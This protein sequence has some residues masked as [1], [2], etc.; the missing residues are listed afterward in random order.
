MNL[1]IRSFEPTDETAV[2]QL[3]NDAG[4]T[5]PW[6]DPRQD[7]QR[8]LSVQ[9]DLFLVGCIED[10]IVA[11][12]MAG[13]DGHRGW[14]YYLAVQPDLQRGGIGRQM[15]EEAESR[16]KSLGCPKIDLMVR[17]TNAKVIDF[18]KSI[19]YKIDDVII[20]GKR[21]E[22]DDESREL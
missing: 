15:M 13:Y 16:L 11:S 4:L 5:V 20:M 8:K 17:S 22:P 2:I 12:V 18:Y 9:G 1:Q 6:N 21:L 10:R 3:W 19:G 14:I 7:I